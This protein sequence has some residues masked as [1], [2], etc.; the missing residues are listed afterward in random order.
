MHFFFVPIFFFFF[1][2]LDRGIIN[3]ETRKS[4]FSSKWLLHVGRASPRRCVNV[5]ADVQTL[6]TS[7]LL[8]GWQLPY[9]SKAC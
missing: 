3:R 7:A 5:P 6:S 4:C 2:F 9:T 8:R 1:F